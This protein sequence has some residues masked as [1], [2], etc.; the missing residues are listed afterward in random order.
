M[1]DHIIPHLVDGSEDPKEDVKAWVEWAL[2]KRDKY[3]PFY[4]WEWINGDEGEE[5][6]P[7]MSV[8]SFYYHY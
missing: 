4:Y 3:Y 1:K 7:T 8:K 6:E 2:T 5:K